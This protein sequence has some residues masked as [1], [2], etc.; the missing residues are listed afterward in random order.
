MTRFAASMMIAFL[1]MPDAPTRAGAEEPME[2]RV[3]L[4]YADLICSADLLRSMKPLMLLRHTLAKKKLSAD[5][6][7]RF[8]QRMKAAWR[9]PAPT[10]EKAL[11]AAGIF[12][13]DLEELAGDEERASRVAADT[14]QEVIR[15][16][17]HRHARGDVELAVRLAIR[18]GADR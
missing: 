2:R 17:R 12:S 13:A 11:A 3:A 15:I 14:F 9:K 1:W 5:G 6:V 7:R 8:Q 10:I 4:V 18:C 16:C